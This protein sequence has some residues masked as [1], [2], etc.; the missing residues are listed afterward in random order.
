MFLTVLLEDGNV[1]TKL[2]S[3]VRNNMLEKGQ[4]GKMKFSILNLKIHLKIH[5]KI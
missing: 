1:G 3:A 2:R 5:L 4:A